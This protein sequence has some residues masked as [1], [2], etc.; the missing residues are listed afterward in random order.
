MAEKDNDQNL[1][2]F[3]DEMEEAVRKVGENPH[4]KLLTREEYDILMRGAIPKT[5]TPRE[6]LRLDPPKS[7]F[8]PRTPGATPR[9]RLQFLLNSSGAQGA[10]QSF[11]VPAYNPPKLPFFSGADEPAKGE[12]S[13]EVWNYE[14][15]CLQNSEYLPEH[16]L[17]HSI[18]SS[19]RGAAR[20]LLIPLGENASVEEILEKLDGFYGNVSSAETIIQ[21]FYNDFQKE[22]ESIAAF[23]SR[24]EQT[25]SRAI[26]Y[27]HMEIAAK[28]S[29]LRSKFWT[30]LKS[31]QLRNSTR[32]LYDTQKDFPS[33]LREIRKVEQEE[34]CSS[35]P[36]PTTKQKVAQQH[37]SQVPTDQPDKTEQIQKQI[38]EL[39]QMMK[40]MEKRLDSQQQALAAANSQSSFQH[41]FNQY[42]RGRGHRGQW[43]DSFGRGNSG[44]GNS[45]RNYQNNFRGNFRGGRSRG[46]GRGGAS[47]RGTNR[48]NNSN[49]GGQPLN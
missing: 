33:L 5:S 34:S 17:L 44:Y 9:S 30:G 46:V 20:D 43:T 27:G 8:N 7:M 23:G 26:R 37:T 28:D 40:S 14:V 1:Q 13:Y 3:G 21:S 2:E 35:R 39:V 47:G 19:L 29:M 24:L 31:Q 49:V 41:D 22:N 10:Q 4:Y 38:S 11:T 48:G 32:Y 18:R 15:K 12:T 42:Q 16:V 6:S 25:L 45:N 36:V